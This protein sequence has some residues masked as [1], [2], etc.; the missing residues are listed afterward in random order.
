LSELSDKLPS[1]LFITGVSDVEKQA[2][3]AGSFGDI[4][5]AS[6][7]NKLVALKRMRY[8]PEVDSHLVHSVSS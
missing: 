6:Y 4:F 3:L 1:S 2:T 8:F 7:Q 5:R